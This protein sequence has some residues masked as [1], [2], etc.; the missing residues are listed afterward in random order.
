MKLTP[1]VYE[2]QAIF[3]QA[4]ITHLGEEVWQ[5]QGEIICQAAAVGRR[6]FQS[7]LG[8]LS[9]YKQEIEIYAELVSLVKT[10]ETQVNPSRKSEVG[11]RK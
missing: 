6:K 9:N 2:N 1:K 4:L 11:G 7:K 10:V 8:W 3:T 5:F